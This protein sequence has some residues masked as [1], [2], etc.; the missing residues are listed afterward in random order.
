MPETVKVVSMALTIPVP[1]R[2]IKPVR[3]VG[4]LAYLT[5]SL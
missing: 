2:G 5:L 3:R 4:F 1:P